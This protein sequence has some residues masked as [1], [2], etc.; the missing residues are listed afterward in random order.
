MKLRTRKLFWLAV[1]AVLVTIEVL[2][3]LFVHDRFIRPYI[4]DLIVVWCV[5]AFCRVLCPVHPPS[6]LPLY[7]FLFAFS[8]EFAQLLHIVDLLGLS[9]SR[10]F[11]ILIGGT[12]DIAD[13]LCYAFGC[14]L[15][16]VFQKNASSNPQ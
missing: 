9:N 6:L 10:F 15:L 2:I 13:L 3:A 8:V 11:S 7:V 12:F 14:C 1:F 4:G 5:Y 16:A